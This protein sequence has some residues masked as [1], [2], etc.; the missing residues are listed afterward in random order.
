M[1]KSY[2]R[3]NSGD[4]APKTLTDHPFY[5]FTLDEE[6]IAFRDAI[7]SPEKLIVFCNAKV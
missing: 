4:S 2:N 3:Y 1:A 5:G 7:W 6:Q